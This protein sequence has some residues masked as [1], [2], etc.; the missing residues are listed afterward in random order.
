MKQETGRL[1]EILHV[2]NQHQ[3]TH[4]INPEKLCNILEDLGPT[5]VKL[6]QIMSMRSDILP[7]KYCH[8]LARLRTDVKPISFDEICELLNKEL[9]NDP[10]QLFQKINHIPVGCASIAQVHEAVLGDGSKV[11]LKIQRPQIKQIMAEDIALL[12]KASGFLN[13]AT[14]TSELIDFRK[15]IDE[16]WETSKEEMDFQKEAQHLQRFYE[17][18]KDVAYVTCPKVYKE[19]SNEHLL[20]MSYVDGIQIDHIEELD[21]NG[22][23]RKEI[24]QKTAQNYCK[25]ILADGFFHADPHPGNLWI[26]GGQIVW[27]DLGMAGNLSEHY[28][29]IMKRAITA[30]LKNDIYELKL[31]LIHI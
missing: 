21:R 5:Y 24:A 19:Y 8:E 10:G 15:V 31:S 3:V 17:D 30:I 11:V 18:Q 12:K 26:S 6:G 7:E 1:K 2:L 28:R 9:H 4:G 29:A 14:G 23:D 25:Q 22:Y 13:F 16:L 27:L 20:V